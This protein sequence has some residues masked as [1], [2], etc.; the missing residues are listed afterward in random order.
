MNSMEQMLQQQKEL[1]ESMKGF[2]SFVETRVSTI[3]ESVTAIEEKQAQLATIDSRMELLEKDIKERENEINRRPG[4][5][6]AQ[7]DDFGEGGFS[8][9]RMLFNKDSAERSWTAEYTGKQRASTHTTDTEG[10]F[11][12]AEEMLPGFVEEARA[13]VVVWD[14]GLITV[15]EGLRGAPV[16]LP[17]ETGSTT[18]A[19]G[20]ENFAPTDSDVTI[21]QMTFNPNRLSGWTQVSRRLDLMSPSIESIVRRNLGRTV[22]LEMDR[23]LLRGSGTND[24]PEGVANT[25]GILETEIATNGGL[26]TID[27]AMSQ[28]ASLEQ[29]NTFGDSVAFVGHPFARHTARSERIPQFDAGATDPGGYVMLPMSNAQFEALLGFPFRVTTT[30]PTN[31]TKG[32]SSN[33]TEVYCGNWRDLHLGLWQ[34]LEFRLSEHAT[35]GTTHAFI[36]DFIFILVNLTADVEIARAT[37]FNL[38]ND[39]AATDPVS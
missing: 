25:T 16:T 2:R 34:D 38:V 5:M 32:S 15:H 27:T 26:Y 4:T 19:W 29:N 3:E 23:V 1:L 13:N 11:L 31:L 14:S 7:Q 28:I 10:G 22:G 35:D 37:S 33:L 39:A 6:G 24:E 9:M 20:G 36:Q 21:G 30:I 8:I 17:T 18:V 12:V